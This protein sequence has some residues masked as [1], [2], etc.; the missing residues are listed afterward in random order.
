MAD[1]NAGY[2]VGDRVQ[3]VDRR[4]ADDRV[5]PGE[6]GFVTAAPGLGGITAYWDSGTEARR[7]RRATDTPR[8]ARGGAEALQRNVVPAARRLPGR[9]GRTLRGEHAA[10]VR[11]GGIRRAE[12]LHVG[13]EAHVSRRRAREPLPAVRARRRRRP[14]GAGRG[15]RRQERGG[16]RVQ[17]Q[18]H[19]G[20]AVHDDGRLRAGLPLPRARRRN[21]RRS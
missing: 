7:D 20:G 11:H 10:G 3:K 5:H 14:F 21:R 9:M 1:G 4:S 13:G 12:G 6:R 2:R 16:R 8:A 17:R 15:M 19:R 18:A